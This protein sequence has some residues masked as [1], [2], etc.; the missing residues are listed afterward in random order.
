M[1]A[2]MCSGASTAVEEYEREMFER[3]SAAGRQSA[4]IQE[5]LTSP[6]ASQQMLAFVQPG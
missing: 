2:T 4:R 1:L 5:I 6:D 3:T